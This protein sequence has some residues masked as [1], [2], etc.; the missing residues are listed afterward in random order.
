MAVSTQFSSA[1]IDIDPD[2]RTV[3]R[4]LR[5]IYEATPDEIRE[6]GMHWYGNVHDAAQKA[7]RDYG[8][9]TRQAAAV[10]AAVSPNMDWERNNINAFDEIGGLTPEHWDAIRRSDRQAPVTRADGK[11]GKAPRSEEAKRL[12]QGLSISSATDSALIK[13]HRIWDEGVDPDEVLNR[14]TA[15]KT[16]SFFHNILAPHEAGHVTVDGRHSDLIV[17]AM[18]PWA[19]RGS[20]RGISSAA[21][22]TG[23]TTRYEEY[24]DHTRAVA[25]HYGI[26]P[27]QFQA[28]VWEGA[29]PIERGFDPS[30][31]KGDPRR[32]QSYSGR[33]AEFHGG[34][35]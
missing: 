1:G 32:G 14:R 24:E 31:T 35:L 25:A 16:N 13:A 26:L 7:A 33:L 20:S 2:R 18:R 28:V 8:R 4:R 29:K 27:H 10:V 19:G 11:M 5:N 17:D 30:R 12:L 23:K 15:P 21:L 3:V 6:A 34:R 9:S 22:K